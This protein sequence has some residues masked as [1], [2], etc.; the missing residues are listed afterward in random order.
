MLT[1]LSHCSCCCSGTATYDTAPD[2]C[3]EIHNLQIRG[4]VGPPPHP[5]PPSH[6][7]ALGRLT[8]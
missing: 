1:L 5:P 6:H 2:D 8:Q 7:T 4:K 3:A